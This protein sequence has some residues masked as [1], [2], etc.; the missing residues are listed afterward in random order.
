[1]IK[2][3][4]EIHNKRKIWFALQD[5]RLHEGVCLELM[6]MM[7]KTWYFFHKDL[8]LLRFQTRTAHFHA[9]TFLL[10]AFTR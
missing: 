9:Y 4:G 7:M 2:Q 1:M 10:E 3:K 6:M 5:P 8:D